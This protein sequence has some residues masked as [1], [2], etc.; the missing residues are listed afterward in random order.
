MNILRP[1]DLYTL[2]G[3]VVWHMNYV[4]VKLLPKEV[5]QAKEVG[6]RNGI[7]VLET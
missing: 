7:I 4:S 6:R 3:K 2:N 1:I 5:N